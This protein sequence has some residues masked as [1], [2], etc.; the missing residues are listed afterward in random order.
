MDNGV[1]QHTGTYGLMFWLWLNNDDIDDEDDDVS[2]ILKFDSFIFQVIE[3]FSS[4][5][6]TYKFFCSKLQRS[7]SG[8][9]VLFLL[10]RT[11]VV[12]NKH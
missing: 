7:E 10:Q 8:K 2:N 6:M 11:F 3:H 12:S 5:R 4:I 9:L 1:K